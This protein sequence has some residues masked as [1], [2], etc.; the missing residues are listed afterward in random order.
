VGTGQDTQQTMHNTRPR[1]AISIAAAIA[2]TFAI[3]A[4][5][6]AMTLPDGAVPIR[7]AHDGATQDSDAQESPAFAGPRID[8][9]TAHWSPVPYRNAELSV[10]GSWLVE[11]YQHAWCGD[12]QSG[13]M[14]FAGIRPHNPGRG[15]HLPAS[16]AW[17]L[18]AGHIPRGT[19]HRKPTA[20]INGIP[21]YREPSGQGSVV[22]LVP[23]LDVRVGA[24]GPRQQSVLSTL[25]RSTL[26]VV[27]RR[28]AVAKVPGNWTWR[29][30]GG[31]EF[32]TPESWPQRR[33]DQW[34]TCGTGLEPRTLLLVKATKPAARLPCPY[35]IPLASAE[36]ARPGLTVVTGKYAASSVSQTY[37]RCKARN[38]ARICLA[39][40][41][42]KGGSYSGVLIFSVARPH[43]HARTFVLLGLAGSG[44]RARAVFDSIRM[45]KA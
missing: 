38:G 10:P 23:D 16:L 45:T 13:G 25:R 30:F 19:R 32:A 40:V 18:P 44:V 3:G 20:V 5:V 33:A 27:T 28:G 31:V 6:L 24:R 9:G 36:R 22:Y 26:S 4:A 8:S 2:T 21:V 15:C 12:P 17:I 14:I 11:T 37:G 42:G 1:T 35:P 7:T 41:T 43:R 29:R 34:A 39:S